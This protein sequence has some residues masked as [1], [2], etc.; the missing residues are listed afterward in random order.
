[1]GAKTI[2][3]R[4]CQRCGR[5]MRAACDDWLAVLELGGVKHV[6]CPGCQTLDEQAEGAIRGATTETAFGTDGR[7]YTRPK[8]NHSPPERN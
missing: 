1:M 6:I 4:R 2:K 5:R 7:F 8:T 3:R